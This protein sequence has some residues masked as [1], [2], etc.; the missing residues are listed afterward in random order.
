MSQIKLEDISDFISKFLEDSD[1]NKDRVWTRAEIEDLIDRASQNQD[2]SLRS[3][4]SKILLSNYQ[5]ITKLTNKNKQI[6]TDPDNQISYW[7]ISSLVAI[8]ENLIQDKKQLK[9]ETNLSEACFSEVLSKI[10]KKAQI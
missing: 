1:Q 7:D 3:Y 6:Y 4:L 2:P 5:L 8:L 9:E 10:Q